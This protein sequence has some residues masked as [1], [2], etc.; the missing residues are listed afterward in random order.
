MTKEFQIKKIL[1]Q[2]L[3]YSLADQ[4]EILFIQNRINLTRFA[5]SEIHQN[6]STNNNFISI[7]VALGKKIGSASTNDF[8]LQALKR[9]IDRAILIAKFQKE[10]PDFISLPKPTKIKKIK[11]FS[12]ATVNCSPQKRA[13]MV[14]IIIDE[15][16][17]KDLI[18]SG[19]LSIDVFKITVANSLG[20]FALFSQTQASLST[21]IMG[22]NNSG[23][24]E[25]T[26]WDINKINPQKVAK[27]AIAKILD[28]QSPIKIKPGIYPVFLEECAVAQILDYM[29][30]LG[31]SGKAIEEERSFLSGKL[32]KKVLGENI[33]IIDDGLNPSG[34]PMPFDFEGVGKKKVVLIE[35]GIFKNR[36]Y[37]SLSAFKEG[38]DSTGHSLPQP[39]NLGAYP[40]NLFLKPGKLSKEK[41]LKGI[42]KGIYITRFWYLNA[43]HHNLLMTGMTRDGTF[44]IEDG[45]IVKPLKNLRFTQSFPQ[46]LSEAKAI[47]RET[48]LITKATLFSGIVSP[49]LLIKRFNFTG[50]TK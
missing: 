19:A 21:I 32:G 6:V 12:L 49:A 31:F 25:Q 2:A 36:V 11:T 39:N 43:L 17:K 16:E 33:T 34:L 35:K 47:S 44:L 22:K 10:N 23:Y 15:T 18:A 45:K 28:D 20:V 50:S 30:Y 41:I 48:K 4:T 1:K 42:K 26:S 40:Q 24:G 8:S 14:K 37:D 3:K 7:R 5:N 27:E 38:R 46:A 9:T 13:Q 29:N